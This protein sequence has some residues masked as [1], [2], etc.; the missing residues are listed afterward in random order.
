MSERA[1]VQSARRMIR[2]V[3]VVVPVLV[4]KRARGHC[5]DRVA[6]WGK[7]AALTFLDAPLTFHFRSLL[8][9]ARFAASIS[10]CDSSTSA[11]VR[12]ES[13]RPPS[14][15]RWPP[16]PGIDAEFP[17]PRERHR[18]VP[19]F[20]HAHAEELA[21]RGTRRIAER[22]PPPRRRRRVELR[23]DLVHFA[24]ELRVAEVAD[25]GPAKFVVSHSPSP[26]S[27]HI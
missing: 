12:V 14:V 10:A 27:A 19:R 13:R 25:R 1:F 7:R 20:D 26:S 11:A 21:S 15:H 9:I 2:I 3:E 8:S 6:K 17:R 23:R 22:Q 18:F 5:R 4:V 16:R 24:I